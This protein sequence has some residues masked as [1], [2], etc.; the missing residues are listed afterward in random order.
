MVCQRQRNRFNVL[1]LKI[2]ES[3]KYNRASRIR[4]MMMKNE[5]EKQ[6]RAKLTRKKKK[7]KNANE[8]HYFWLNE[9][10]SHHGSL[11]LREAAAATTCWLAGW[12]RCDHAARYSFAITKNPKCNEVACFC[13]SSLHLVW[14]QKR[15]WE[16]EHFFFVVR[17]QFSWTISFS[18]CIIL[19]STEWKKIT[20]NV[21]S[22]ATIRRLWRPRNDDD[23]VLRR[24]FFGGAAKY[25]RTRMWAYQSKAKEHRVE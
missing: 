8:Q 19:S 5:N 11:R 24:V 3:R 17:H 10:Q 25:A 1:I 23:D 13:W 18:P 9:K 22:A 15:E 20:L 6:K 7:K 14:V 16:R 12:C 4:E 2:I 21:V